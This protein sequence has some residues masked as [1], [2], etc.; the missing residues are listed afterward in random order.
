MTALSSRLGF[1]RQ[2][3]V[4]SLI[5][6]VVVVIIGLI[7]M[8]VAEKAQIR[9]ANVFF[10]NL[11]LVF[12]LQITMGNSNVANLGHITFMGVAAYVVGILVLPLTIKATG[13]PNA[14]FGLAE[15]LIHFVPAA[16]IAVVFSTALAFITG[17]VLT[18]Q[19]GIAYSIA[20]LAL[21]VIVHTVL[22]NWVDLTRGPIAMYGIPIRA[23]TVSLMLIAGACAIVARLFRD[24][25]W[26]LQL[27]ASGEDVLGAEASGVSVRTLRLVA[28]TLSG[29]VLSIGGVMYAYMVGTINPKSFY[30]DAVFLTLA[31]LI[32]GGMRSVSGAVVGAVIITLG[33]ELMRWLEGAPIIFGGKMPQ[34]FGLTGFFLGVVI[35]L[36]MA[37]RPD[38]L[39]GDE[40][41][42]ELA[43]RLWRQRRAKANEAESGED[44]T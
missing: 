3:M 9:V 8:A 40:E 25:R 34:I 41:F 30:F 42:D 26:G 15:V 22:T 2:S 14:P 10:V 19:T 27:R 18:R 12:G 35:V 5:L 4:G 11:I 6:A 23:N 21:L 13:I 1:G 29:F 37:L 24:S 7:V 31:M 28:W 38:G 16:M 36:F 44:E 32:L 39:I 20:T 17:L 43:R 33:T